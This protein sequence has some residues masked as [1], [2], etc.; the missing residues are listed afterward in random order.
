MGFY[1][2]NRTQDIRAAPEQRAEQWL[3]ADGALELFFKQATS[4][5]RSFDKDEALGIPALAGCLEFICGIAASVPV[6][7]YEV[8]TGEG[9]EEEKE[10]TN[11]PRLAVLNDDTGDL[12]TG[13]EWKKAFFMDYLLRGR[14]W[15]YQNMNLNRL[16]SLHYVDDRAVS[17]CTNED[18]VFKR[19]VVNIHGRTYQ[20]WQFI[21]M[22]RNTTDGVRGVG[23]LEQAK[24]QLSMALNY[25]DFENALVKGG[26][27]KRGFLQS[28]RKLDAE[29]L[30]D[31]KSNF[32]KM[33]GGS[34]D[35][36]VVLNKGVTFT[37]AQATSVEMQLAE[38][39]A[40]N[41]E[42][43]CS[44]LCLPV[45]IITGSAKVEEFSRAIQ[46]AVLPL[47]DGFDKALNRATLLESE[48]GK[49]RFACDTRDLES[50]DLIKRYNAYTSACKAGWLSKNEIRHKE[51]YK[52][53]PG[54][55]VVSLGLG[56]VLYDIDTGK[57]FVPNTG[58][59]VN[60]QEVGTEEPASPPVH[61]KTSKQEGENKD[62]N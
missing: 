56:D 53:I 29:M 42:E 16:E 32:E 61:T 40:R 44:L 34:N 12:L 47:L 36:V 51:K 27:S 24:Q 35:A 15:A 48:K 37:P 59:S 8:G 4:V 49:L 62:E 10:V 50:S 1:K 23:L 55:N 13:P 7:L 26:G 38:N 21:H 18:P 52:R 46:V 31:L 11:D 14:A 39:K 25:I 43:I 5:S 33:Y 30:Q 22:A 45:S 17:V 41:R 19:A 9:Q 54:L 28:E 3:E 6:R 2:R 20:P 57:F 58:Q 60:M